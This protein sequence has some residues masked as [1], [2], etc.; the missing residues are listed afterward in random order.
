[1]QIE[2][3]ARHSR[4]AVVKSTD[5]RAETFPWT[6]PQGAPGR[7]LMMR[8]RSQEDGNS[9]TIWELPSHWTAA[10]ALAVFEVL[11]DLRDLV[12][13]GYVKKIQPAA[14]LDRTVTTSSPPEIKGY[15]K[16]V[17]SFFIIF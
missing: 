17:R 15:D 6:T 4:E 10:Q 2:V 3:S 12:V 11:D 14:R 16:G 8:Q 7:K 5:R 9:S 1:M 13:D